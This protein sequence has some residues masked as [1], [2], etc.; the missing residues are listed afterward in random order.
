[1]LLRLEVSQ[2]YSRC[3][4]QV[5]SILG[6]GTWGLR[7]RHFLRS[8]CVCVGFGRNTVLPGRISANCRIGW[9]CQ[10]TTRPDTTSRPPLG[11]LCRNEIYVTANA[12]YI[13]G[14]SMVLH[15]AA[16]ANCIKSTFKYADN[17]K[18]E[19]MRCKKGS[20]K[21]NPLATS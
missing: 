10:P 2:P 21:L 20:S 13:I 11:P 14:T 15:L 8:N 6:W 9:R 17:L 3:N 19:I 12:G 1:M 7:Q 4:S 5:P 18:K 16:P